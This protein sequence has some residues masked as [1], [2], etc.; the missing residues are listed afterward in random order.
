MQAILK[1]QILQLN[2]Y[3]RL[4]IRSIH[5]KKWFQVFKM[6]T[7]QGIL[8]LKL[9]KN[10]V[11]KVQLYRKTNLFQKLLE[12]ATQLIQKFNVFSLNET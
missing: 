10:N 11:A 6:R 8:I 1:I 12:T 4:Y 2:D 9:K 7:F 3:N 5:I